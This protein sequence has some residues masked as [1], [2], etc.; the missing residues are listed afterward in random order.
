MTYL[1]SFQQYY[2]FDI[3]RWNGHKTVINKDM[4]SAKA[5]DNCLNKK[6]KQTE[7]EHVPL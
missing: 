1:A 5:L 6:K 2:S 4:V 7:I 3:S